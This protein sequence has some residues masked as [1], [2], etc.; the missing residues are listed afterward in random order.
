MADS[1]TYIRVHDGMPENAKVEALSDRAFRVLID[2]WC[3]CSRT[4]SDGVI[5]EAVWVKRTGTAKV[6]RELLGGLVEKVDGQFVM[7]D[8]LEHQRSRAE[9]EAL[10][11]K[12]AEAGRKGGKARSTRQAN[13]EASASPGAKQPGS[14]IQP[15]TETDTDTSR[16]DGLEAS[17]ARP[18]V[19]RI[20]EHLAAAVE[21]NGSKRPAITQR[22]RDEARR[23]L[24][25]DGRTVDQ[26]L[27]AID[28][29]QA[30]G[31]WRANILSVPKLREKYDQLRLAAE[32]AQA[33]TRSADP[34]GEM[35]RAAMERAQA[36][37]A[38]D[39]GLPLEVGS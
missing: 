7:H 11:S 26:V 10:R 16:P 31:F 1:R 14:K 21:A 34:R 5:P 24:D 25:L 19:D 8:Y 18:D 33:P 15:S 20:C 28:W 4:L 36:M 29:S 30:D 13:A 35:L 2:L 9:V 27:R 37:D 32:R 23:M 39:G 17:V 22:W 38:A 6:Q 3:W 12:R